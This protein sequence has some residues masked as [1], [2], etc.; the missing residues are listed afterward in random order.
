MK[1]DIIDSWSDLES[2]TDE[3][4]R[5]LWDS[6]A[7]T[8]FLTW[9]WVQSW[10]KVVGNSV[11]PFVVSV[12]DE[13]G[14]LIGLAPFYMGEFRLLGT[15]PY[16]TLRIMA[17]Y[18]TGS[19]YPDWISLKGREDEV[20][21]LIAKTLSKLRSKWDC[22]WMKSMAGWTG[23]FERIGQVCK[24][25]GF[26]CHS[27]PVSFGFLY[28]SENAERYLKSLSKNTREQLRRQVKKIFENNEIQIVHCQDMDDLPGFLDVLFDLHHRRWKQRGQQGTFNKKPSEALFYREFTKS[29][30]QNG[31]LRLVGLKENG[32]FKAIQI[33]YVYN[34]IFHQIQ[35]GFDP[36]YVPG[37]GNV[38]RLKVIEECIAEAVKAY[39]FLGD[40]TEH[41]RK[42]LA[43]ERMGY[44]LFI[45]NP[46]IKNQILFTKEIWPT[47][48]FLRPSMLPTPSQKYPL[49]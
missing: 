27:R 10:M 37:V 17:D 45:G 44:D 34:D 19:E 20:Y 23:A 31:W 9:E 11:H 2:L 21:S 26:Y 7:N 43:K 8:I 14:R 6:H 32:S 1:I 41:K 3:W 39:D 4:N 47:G 35:E 15:I 40:M 46:K 12:R 18:A 29:A 42:W 49:G 28:L 24:Q 5:L 36:E 38:L 13:S 16:R 25:E 33:G 22:L 48:R 30:L